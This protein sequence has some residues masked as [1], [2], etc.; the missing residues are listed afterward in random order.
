M[1]AQPS[2]AGAKNGSGARGASAD[3]RDVP[4]DKPAIDYSYLPVRHVVWLDRDGNAP[5]TP[6]APGAAPPASPRAEGPAPPGEAAS[7]EPLAAPARKMPRIAWTFAIVLALVGAGALVHQIATTDEP[8]DAPPST[9][10]AP[11][12][13]QSIEP[14]RAALPPAPAEAPPAPDIA[15]LQRAAEAGDARAEYELG[16]R[17]VTG[18][19]LARDT[20][21]GA[22]WFE[23]AAVKGHAS[24]QYN[25]GV[26]FERGLGVELNDDVAF[27]WY[28]LAAEQAHPRAQHNL[29]TAYARGRG[30]TQ[31]FAAAAEWY[32]RSAAAGVAESQHALGILYEQGSGVPK[33]AERALALYRAAA[34][35]GHV[36]AAESATRL[37]AAIAPAGGAVSRAPE[38]ATTPAAAVPTRDAIAEI[39]RLLRRLNFDPG[40]A[41]GIAGARTIAAIKL[42]QKFAGL[43]EDGRPSASL[44]ED[45][46]EVAAAKALPPR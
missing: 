5:P 25:L 32:A 13:T 21:E 40:A 30:A 11:A 17:H 31:D 1:A 38:I 4:A 15:E 16:V 39:Q 19:G 42:Y 45:L 20:A 8:E 6:F 34:S 14:P 33:D 10:A 46:R 7:P 3:R 23:R 18:R 12:P 43:P 22:R 29:A 24:A 36:G 9:N 28:R 26:M 35:Q 44:L 2:G 41:D 37:A 27:Y